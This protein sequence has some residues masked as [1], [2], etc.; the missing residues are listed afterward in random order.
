MNTTIVTAYFE[1]PNSKAS[2]TKY[3]EWMQNMLIIDCPMIIFCDQKSK[4][5]ISPFR[6]KWLE[7]TY[8]ITLTFEEFHCFRYF[9]VF[10]NDYNTKD[11]EK[12]H[13]PYL[14][15]IWNEKT[16]FLKRAVEINHFQHNFFLWVDIGCFRKPNTQFLHWPN[17]EKINNLPKD[18]ILLLL[19]N[20]FTYSEYSVA[21]LNELPDFILSSGRIGGTIFGGSSSTILK[22]HDLYYSMIEKFI[23]MDRFIG[24]DQ[25]IMNSIAILNKDFIHIV[26]PS[27][28]YDDKW[29]YLQEFLQ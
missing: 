18:K 23:S 5:I 6:E 1:L 15:L 7:Q 10:V 4:E 21:T 13:N 27:L 8:F 16:H 17:P 29:F 22:W 26:E 9:N 20:P 2:P 14:Y 3:N 25:N 12:Y 28:P 19:V 24:K 11:H